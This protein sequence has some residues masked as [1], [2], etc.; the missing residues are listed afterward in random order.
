MMAAWQELPR[1]LWLS[2]C[3]KLHP[4]DVIRLSQTCKE[5]CQIGND[6]QI[7]QQI[8]GDFASNKYAWNAIVTF[9]GVNARLSGLKQQHLA[10]KS[11]KEVYRRV[12]EDLERDEITMA[13]LTMNRWLFSF[14]HDPGEGPLELASFR[15]DNTYVSTF[16]HREPIRFALRHSGH[17]VQVHHYPML[18][19]TR[20]KTGQWQLENSFVVFRQLEPN[21]EEQASST[22]ALAALQEAAHAHFNGPFWEFE[23]DY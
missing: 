11:W 7:W 18:Y 16:F 19:V 14:K 4:A 13:E 21:Q 20:L 2:I 22:E 6:E 15:S 3:K 12:Y 9:D 17:T 8:F 10:R 23:D 5:L 1:E